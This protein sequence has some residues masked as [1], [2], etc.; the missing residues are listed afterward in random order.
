MN[1]LLENLMESRSIHNNSEIIKYNILKKNVK[2][3]FEET[4]KTS[5]MEIKR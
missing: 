4:Y 5:L 2:N 1:F 3:L